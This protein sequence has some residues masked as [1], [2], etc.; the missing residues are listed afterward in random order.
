MT[1]KLSLS[2]CAL[3]AAV[4]LVGCSDDNNGNG[5]GNDGGSPPALGAQLDRQG[6][7]AVNVALN[8]TFEADGGVQGN[9]KNAYNSAVPSSASSFTPELAKNLGVY[10]GLDR[11]CGNQLLAGA[12]ADAGR[13]DAL[14]QVLA[15]DRLFVDTRQATCAQYLAVE[16]SPADGGTDCGG[17]APSYDVID[18]TYSVVAAGELSGVTDNVDADGDG[19][20]HSDTEFPF[21]GATP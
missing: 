20:L 4:T 11:S 5:N 1:C 21:L 8:A 17:R 19:D 16:T 10:D 15:D 6:R 9:A 14:A 13:Y 3:L 2:M 12:T 18:T 7:P